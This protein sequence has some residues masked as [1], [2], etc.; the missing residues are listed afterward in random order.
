MTI[1]GP[2]FDKSG[3][4]AIFSEAVTLKFVEKAKILNYNYF[5]ELQTVLCKAMMLINPFAIMYNKRS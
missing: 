2:A 1:T 5:N 3:T 4:P